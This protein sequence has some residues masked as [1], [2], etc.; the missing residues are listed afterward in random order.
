MTP[1]ELD[2]ARISELQSGPPDAD[3]KLRPEVLQ[4][5]IAKTLDFIEQAVVH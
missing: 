2:K 1:K 4:Q 3:A 5:A